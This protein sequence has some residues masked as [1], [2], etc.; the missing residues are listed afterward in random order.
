MRTTRCPG[1]K[2]SMATTATIPDSAAR[3]TAGAIRFDHV[4]KRF[5]QFEAV[6]DLNLD[7]RDGELLVLLGPSGCGKTTTL[8]MLAGL[9]QPTSGTLLFGDKVMNNVPPEER[10]I[11]MVFQSIALYPHLNV[12]DN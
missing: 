4:G 12:R 11:A 9:E 5:E 3:H 2:G 7:I 1:E 8:N 6:R 10:D